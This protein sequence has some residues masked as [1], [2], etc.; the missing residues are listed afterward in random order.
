[1]LGRRVRVGANVTIRDSHIW[2]D[3]VI[4]DGAVRAPW[5]VFGV[6]VGAVHST[7]GAVHSTASHHHNHHTT[8][9]ETVKHKTPPYT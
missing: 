6:A 9:S 1:M 7:V 4:E 8:Q 3:V 5:F 2:N